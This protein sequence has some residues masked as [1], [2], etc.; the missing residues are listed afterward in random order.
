MIVYLDTHTLYTNDDAYD[1][2]HKHNFDIDNPKI[3]SNIIGNIHKHERFTHEKSIIVSKV[4]GRSESMGFYK[5]ITIGKI[6][7]S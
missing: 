1:L 7:E 2:L 4:I 5:F 6:K 3:N